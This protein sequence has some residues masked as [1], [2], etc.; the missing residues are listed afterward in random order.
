MS[1]NLIAA[2]G[3]A[4]VLGG[5]L[6]WAFSSGY[7]QVGA[8]PAESAARV[9]TENV[10]VPTIDTVEVPVSDILVSINRERRQSLLLMDLTIVAPEYYQEAIEKQN[11]KIVNTVLKA[12]GHKS[13]AYFY[14]S[15]FIDSVQLELKAELSNALGIDIKEILVTKAVYQ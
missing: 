1:K 11:A 3:A 9:Q 6:V 7:I 14:G 12:L 2:V 4:L 10:V 13:E 8:K 5:G 15:N